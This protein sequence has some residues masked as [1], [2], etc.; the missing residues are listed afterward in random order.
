MA[1][2]Q[3]LPGEKIVIA[4]GHIFE[5]IKRHTILIINFST[6]NTYFSDT[7]FGSILVVFTP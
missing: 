1:K 2:Y 5:Y 3:S 7:V 6:T 4:L